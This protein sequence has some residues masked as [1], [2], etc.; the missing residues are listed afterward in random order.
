MKKIETVYIA[1][2]YTGGSVEG[3]VQAAIDAADLVMKL[4]AVPFVPHLSHF[5]RPRGYEEWMRFDFVWLGKCDAL[6]RIPGISPGADREVERMTELGRPIFYTI[7][8][9]A[10]YLKVSH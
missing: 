3:N 10:E 1:G 5:L 4:G 2:P 7:E 9:L 6:L 8:T